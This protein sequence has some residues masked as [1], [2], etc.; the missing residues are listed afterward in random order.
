MYVKTEEHIYLKI[1]ELK[2]RIL[3]SYIGYF[4]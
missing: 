1:K 3:N 2:N 4:N